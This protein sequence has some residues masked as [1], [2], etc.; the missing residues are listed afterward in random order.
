MIKS[1]KEKPKLKL[2]GAET[3]HLVPFVV[4]LAAEMFEA[5]KNQHTQTILTMMTH[6]VTFY[7]CMGVTP[8]NAQMAALQQGSAFWRM[9][10]FHRKLSL[11]YSG[12]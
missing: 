10:L 9:N 4:E 11:M 6:L 8:L 2:K 5:K 12:Q 7:R 3:R 1:V